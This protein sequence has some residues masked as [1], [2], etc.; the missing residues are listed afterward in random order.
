MAS[1]SRRV[2]VSPGG[3]R[4]DDCGP[5][6]SGSYPPDGLFEGAAHGVHDLRVGV[7]RSQVMAGQGVEVE[8]S[9]I[10]LKKFSCDQRENMAPATW[11][12]GICG[13]VVITHLATVGETAPNLAAVSPL[14]RTIGC[15]AR[16]NWFRRAHGSV[17][18]RKSSCGQLTLEVLVP[19]AI[20]RR[21][22]RLNRSGLQPSRSNTDAGVRPGQVGGRFRHHPQVLQVR[23]HVLLD[24]LDQFRVQRLVQAQ[25]GRSAEGVDPVAHG[26]WQRTQPLDESATVAPG[27]LHGRPRSVLRSRRRARWP[28]CV[29]VPI[30]NRERCARRW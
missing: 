3:P 29:P 5:L 20:P 24:G 1:A 17:P 16:S 7:K 27:D 2:A 10:Y 15:S 19:Q 30:A 22:R 4:R 14:R 13:W 9:R 11:T 6:P 25:Q 28:R 8:L 18:L 23:H 21:A 26:R 12:K